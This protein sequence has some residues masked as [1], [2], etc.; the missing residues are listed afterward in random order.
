MGKILQENMK[1]V[2]EIENKQ[3]VGILNSLIV[4]LKDNVV[5]Y[6]N[7]LISALLGPFENLHADI[8]AYMKQF[9][10]DFP[11][12]INHTHEEDT[13]SDKQQKQDFEKFG[14]K[15]SVAME[16]VKTMYSVAC[17]A[18]VS[19][20]VLNKIEE[21]LRALI[22]SCFDDYFYCQ[23]YLDD[24]LGIMLV[25]I[26]NSDPPSEFV[27]KLCSQVANGYLQYYSD[28]FNLTVQIL[29][30][31]IAASKKYNVSLDNFMGC[32]MIETIFQMLD[33]AATEDGADLRFLAAMYDSLCSTYKGKQIVNLDRYL[34]GDDSQSSDTCVID[35]CVSI[36]LDHNYDSRSTT[37]AHILSVI[38]YY[39]PLKFLQY[40]CCKNK[41]NSGQ[42]N[43][44]SSNKKTN[45]TKFYEIMQMI[46]DISDTNDC[47]VISQR[48]CAIGLS[49]LFT[50]DASTIP[51][52]F[53]S[54][55]YLQELRRLL[56]V[57]SNLVYFFHLN[58]S[59]ENDNDA[60]DDKNQKDQNIID[61]K[62]DDN[63]EE[64]TQAIDNSSHLN[65]VDELKL[66][67]FD[68]KVNLLNLNADEDFVEQSS[69]KNLAYCM[70]LGCDEVMQALLELAYAEENVPSGTPLDSI[71]VVVYFMQCAAKLNNGPNSFK[72]VLQDWDQNISA[73]MK[74]LFQKCV[75]KQK[76]N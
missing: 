66:E 14:H 25:L 13:R 2:I 35:K 63:N 5:P 8:T 55:R 45:G 9:P 28:K 51:D 23:P 29:I 20:P 56:N 47:K 3:M 31:Y 43:N 46:T 52:T 19:P 70:D 72:Q 76:R 27:W 1:L 15:S 37:M 69:V 42:N 33:I 48:A 57:I 40:F 53:A 30:G 36:L 38:M 4:T 54:V 60:T 26:N 59:D 74:K 34:F 18:S 17:A 75:D 24:I 41:T 64:S 71:N 61:N 11:C 62:T 73:K 68:N 21:K 16:Y 67:Y 7:D 65:S 39:D 22:K 44:K 12:D 32:N 58:Y 10:R 49:T 50:I 6:T